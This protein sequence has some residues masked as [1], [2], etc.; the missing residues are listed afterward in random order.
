MNYTFADFKKDQMD[1]TMPHIKDYDRYIAFYEQLGKDE[2]QMRQ[3]PNA[4][5]VNF[6]EPVGTILEVGCHV[7]YNVIHFAKLGFYVTGVDISS[8]LI[9]EAERRVYFLPEE[10]Q[11]RI[12]L[13]C[14]DILYLDAMERFDTVLLMEVLEH[15]ID[16]FGVL[17]KCV[18]FMTADAKIYITA[19]AERIGNY[20][21]VRGVTEEWLREA[22]QELGL[23]FEFSNYLYKQPPKIIRTRLR[24]DGQVVG[25]VKTAAKG[26]FFDTQAIGTLCLQE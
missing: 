22:G 2:E 21:H 19:P 18:Q 4:R 12:T 14:S 23:D 8:S 1:P 5:R 6:V 15:V 17:K 11:D 25:V 26:R 24:E 10:V 16:P 13:V 20:A 7:G 9:E 3:G